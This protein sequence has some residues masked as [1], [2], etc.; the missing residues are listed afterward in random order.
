MKKSILVLFS[1][2]FFSIGSFP[3]FAQE[4]LNVLFRKNSVY[5]SIGLAGF[6]VTATGNFERILTQ[7]LE[8]GITATFAKIGY[9]TY[10][11]WGDD[12]QYLY[13]QYGFITG[14]KGSHF[15]MSAGPNFVV[16]GDMDLPVAFTLGYRHQKPGKPFMFRTGLAGPESLYVGI[17]FSF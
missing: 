7:S 11:S 4:S 16:M 15:E 8:K 6:Y 10:G 12:G 5:G 3:A 2:C 17:G 13:V 1:L 9:G 14:K